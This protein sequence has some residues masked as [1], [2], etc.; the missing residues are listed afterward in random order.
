MRRK[1]AR[2][3]VSGPWRRSVALYLIPTAT[4]LLTGVSVAVIV[5]ALPA[6]A[7]QRESL[8]SQTLSVAQ[9]PGFLLDDD[10]ALDPASLLKSQSLYF[11]FVASRT[12]EAGHVRRFTAFDG[13]ASVAVRLA[14]FINHQFAAA[15]R[16]DTAQRVDVSLPPDTIAAIE[17][18]APGWETARVQIVKGRVRADI[19]IQM[20][21]DGMSSA[22]VMERIDGLVLRVSRAQ[23]DDIAW[24]PDLSGADRVSTRPLQVALLVVL[25]LLILVPQA[26]LALLT[27]MRDPAARQR[28]RLHRHRLPPLCA[29]KPGSARLI[30]VSNAARDRLRRCRRRTV[31]RTLVALAA[32]AATSQLPLQEQMFALAI[33]ALVGAGAEAIWSRARRSS[34][35]Q[36]LWG[37]PTGLLTLVGAAFTLALAAAGG[38]LLFVYVSQFFVGTLPAAAARSFGA[39]LFIAGMVLVGLSAVPYILTRRLSLLLARRALA[40]DDRKEVLFLR[41]WGDDYFRMRARR[42]SR[43]ALL[44]RLSFGRWD[45]FEEIVVGEVRKRGP[46][47]AF[48][49]PGTR[50]PPRGAVRE[51]QAEHKW[52]Q[53]VKEHID[54]SVLTIMTVDRTESVVWEMQQIAQQRAL[55]KTVFLFPPVENEDRARRE[56]VL[57]SV[58]GLPVGQFSEIRSSGRQVLAATVPE[59]RSPTLMVAEV[60]DDVSYETA[61]GVATAELLATDLP[62]DPVPTAKLAAWPADLPLVIRPRGR[63]PPK[64]WYRRWYAVVGGVA[65]LLGLLQQTL[66]RLPGGTS[67]S[68]AIPGSVIL[69]HYDPVTMGYT[70]KSF[71]ALDAGQPALITAELPDG[72]QHVLRLRDTPDGFLVH[73]SA[74]YLTFAQS[75]RLSAFSA[76]GKRTKP[77]WSSNLGEVTSGLAATG[78]EVFVALPASNRIAVL[79]ARTGNRLR[80]IRVGRAPIGLITSD[81]HLFVTN[82]NDGTLSAVDLHSLAAT[83]TMPIGIGPRSLALAGDRILADDVIR[84]RIIIIDPHTMSPARS[85]GV[86]NLWD[87]LAAN[88]RMLVTV[89]SKGSGGWPEIIFIDLRTGKTL[90][91]IPVPDLPTELIMDSKSLLA[92]LPDR[93][94]IVRIRLP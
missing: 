61:L 66:D 46:V 60:S 25:F 78:S 4:V 82:A 57:C 53:A 91:R 51:V 73:G 77:V 63:R 52:R 79:N 43:H 54:E 48:A 71:V 44:E 56:Y 94:V 26:V 88:R 58:F 72:K 36:E 18:S 31:V 89:N 40:A 15:L 67:P 83:A 2:S 7:A 90:R 11:R 30:D 59:G 22:R 29:P 80:Y 64:P 93:H 14:E 17:Q 45:R 85:I 27:F 8:A 32:I 35:P 3:C 92:A 6:I 1:R 55:Y 41:S 13:S 21:V 20:R 62:P 10:R 34:D 39:L 24:T 68:P 70:G 81:H 76:G 50:L 33:L 9:L 74:V 16:P 47:V 87:V 5:P 75:N 84:N 65:V 12:I 49:E 37:V 86:P 28:V 42:A 69:S 23:Y 19:V 38:V